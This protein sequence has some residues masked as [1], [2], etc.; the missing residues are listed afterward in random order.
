MDNFDGLKK[1]FGSTSLEPSTTTLIGGL[2]EHYKTGLLLEILVRY[3]CSNK[4]P[5]NRNEEHVLITPLPIYSI[6]MNIMSMIE[7]IDNVTLS[8]SNSDFTVDK[9][10]AKVYDWF[11]SKGHKLTLIPFVLP[12][13][14][15]SAADLR[16]RLEEISSN[17]NIRLILVDEFPECI[18]V[19][20]E[21]KDQDIVSGLKELSRFI[22]ESGASGFFTY[23]LSEEADLL[24]T[25]AEFDGGVS[26]FLD[27]VIKG[28]YYKTPEEVVGL[29][30]NEVVVYRTKENDGWHL[31]LKSRGIDDVIG[32]ELLRIP[33]DK[34]NPGIIL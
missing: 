33:F 16:S 6:A 28:R 12:H 34:V 5:F 8:E 22:N 15:P 24:T 2:R 17:S 4:Q 30:N 14:R 26:D 20:E 31:Y 11:R 21:S 29:V 9:K 7:K 23:P 13:K 25:I 27:G 3:V 18:K 10:E 1:V 32:N 19:V